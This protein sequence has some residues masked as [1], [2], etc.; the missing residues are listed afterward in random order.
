[1]KMKLHSIEL[2][3]TVSTCSVLGSTVLLRGLLLIFFLVLLLS[4]LI[5]DIPFLKMSYHVG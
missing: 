2:P 4:C 1:M 3:G 5:L